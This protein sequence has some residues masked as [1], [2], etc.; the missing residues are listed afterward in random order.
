M[1][2]FP[3]PMEEMLV[4]RTLSRTEAGAYLDTHHPTLGIETKE[5]LLKMAVPD[6]TQPGTVT[7]MPESRA[8]VVDPL[9][10]NFMVI[11]Y[12]AG[13]SQYQLGMRFGVQRQ[14]VYSIIRKFRSLVGEEPTKSNV[15]VSSARLEAWWNWWFSE[16]TTRNIDMKTTSFPHWISQFHEIDTEE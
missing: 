12:Y 14:T 7:R 13:A 3:I 6:L 10:N 15:K 11:A 16:P 5:A 1:N 2:I 8:Y 4:L 9:R